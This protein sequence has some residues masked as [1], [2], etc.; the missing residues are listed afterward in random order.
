MNE[1]Y[2]KKA[3]FIAADA[4]SVEF[5]M[6]LGSGGVFEADGKDND[7]D[8]GVPDEEDESRIGDGDVCDDGEKIRYTLNGGALQREVGDSTILP[9]PPGG[10]GAPPQTI[11]TNVERLD[12]VYFNDSI[13]TPLTVPLDATDLTEVD[14]VEI[15]LVVRATNEDYRYNDN[16]IY[17]NLQGTPLISNK[18]DNFRRR[19]FSMSVQIRNNI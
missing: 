13:A 4:T 19:V 6:D 11:I 1:E 3:G 2:V 14:R 9:C 17:S 18:A 5:S 8:G 16:V 7:D 15:T 10:Y 12:F